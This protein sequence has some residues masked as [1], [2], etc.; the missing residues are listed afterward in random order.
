MDPITQGIAAGLAVEAIKSMVIFGGLRVRKRFKKKSPRELALQNAMTSALAQTIKSITANQDKMPI[1]KTVFEKWLSREDVAVELSAILESEAE[2]E[3]VLD[4]DHLIM[5]LEDCWEPTVFESNITQ[6]NVVETL[7]ANLMVA[8]AKEPV[9]QGEVNIRLLEELKGVVSEATIDIKKMRDDILFVGEDISSRLGSKDVDLIS[10][11]LRQVRNR[12]GQLDLSPIDTDDADASSGYQRVTLKDVY[13]GLNLKGGTEDTFQID[14]SVGAPK[15]LGKTRTALESFSKHSKMLLLGEPGGGKTTFIQYLSYCLSTC[16]LGDVSSESILFEKGWPRE[17]MGLVPVPIILRDLASWIERSKTKA[18]KGSLF[19]SFLNHLLEGWGLSQAI[20]PIMELIHDEKVVLLLD[21]LDEVAA[22]PEIRQRVMR[23]IKDIPNLVNNGPI[24]VTCRVLSYREDKNLQ[25]DKDWHQAE[26]DLFTDSQVDQFIDAWFRCRVSYRLEAIPVN[27]CSKL[28]H[29]VRRPGLRELYRIPLLLVVMAIVHTKKGGLPDASVLLYEEII[30]ILLSRWDKVKAESKKLSPLKLTT[31][32]NEAGTDI[33]KLLMVVSRVAFEVHEGF[34]EGSQ[35]T[36]DSSVSE[37]ISEAK[38]KNAIK[39]L[40]PDHGKMPPTGQDAAWAEKVVHAMKYRA[41]LLV[42]K[43]EGSFYFPHRVF[44]EHLAARYL[45]SGDFIKSVTNLQ[46]HREAWRLVILLAVARYVRI[47]GNYFLPLQ[48]SASLLEKAD[49]SPQN[50]RRWR[51]IWLAGDCLREIGPVDL[52]N[53]PLGPEILNKTKGLLIEL[54]EQEGLTPREREEAAI[55]LSQLGDDRLGVGLNSNG[56]PDIQWVDIDGKPFI[57]GD[58]HT[59]DDETP[60]F[61]CQLINGKPY[62]ISKYPITVKQYKAFIEDGGYENDDYWQGIPYSLKWR[63]ENN[64]N[65]PIDCGSPFNM[66]NH[67]QV[68]VSWFEAMAFCC[69]LSIKTGTDISLPTEA[70]WERAARGS[71]GREY[72][73]G[74]D[75]DQLKC[76]CNDGRIGTTSAVGIFPSGDAKEKSQTISDLSGNV[77]EWCRTIRRAN[78]RDYERVV[79]ENLTKKGIRVLRGGSFKENNAY[80]RGAYRNYGRPSEPR[81]EILFHT[82]DVLGFRVVS[83]RLKRRK[84]F[85]FNYR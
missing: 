31:F 83:P 24:L 33:T 47:I 21:G 38:L 20:Q 9:L 11:Y 16:Q 60:S 74:K 13:I 56:L 73:W 5:S 8:V 26:L 55:V 59:L 63:N 42:E 25:F 40:H 53:E 52:Q 72:P 12:S 10:R 39:S 54:C 30:D 69:W 22:E 76:N 67:P 70:Q 34:S 45:T 81:S 50:E 84:I 49:T 80:V 27:F 82:P 57:M 3:D 61:S 46:L 29:A 32:L 79:D 64:V 58:S 2:A 15:S 19:I 68:G 71:R 65:A 77:Y 17:R 7:S 48:L 28:K 6:K 78:Y 35:N 66:D 18:E 1:L 44:Q 51:Y 14:E 36:K 85:K 41:G 37:E 43:S 62:R 4:K 75:F 23:M